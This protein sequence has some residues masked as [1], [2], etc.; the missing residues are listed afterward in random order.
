MSMRNTVVIIGASLAG[1][2]AAE[3]LRDEGFAGKIV[4]IGEEQDAPYDRPPLSKQLLT[5][6]WRESDIQLLN[7]EEWEELDIDLRLN[8]RA[9]GVDV[10]N[11]RV[12]LET[13][14]DVTYD[15]LIIATGSR[16]RTILTKPHEHAHVL[17]SLADARRL[18]GA[19][20]AG[21]RSLGIVGGGFIGS[22]VAYGARSLGH[23]VMVL[24]RGPGPMAQV[25]GPA[26]AAELAALQHTHGVNLRTDVVVAGVRDVEGEGLQI[27]LDDGSALAF[28]EVLVSVGAIPNVEWLADSGLEIDGGIVC[29]ARLFAGDDIV[30]AGDVVRVR[31]AGVINRRIEHWTDTVRQAQT[32]AANLLAGPHRALP[33]QGMPYVWSDQFGTRI[34]VIGDPTAGGCVEDVTTSDGGA[35][36]GRIFRYARDGNTVALVSVGAPKVMLQVRR[37]VLDRSALAPLRLA[38]VADV[39]PAK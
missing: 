11:H 3:A 20:S 15:G 37:A 32:A 18:A 30:A 29:D 6:K 13:G 17:R 27:L 24:E 16:P 21:H 14:T 19:L 23:D 10:K 2:R 1:T 4:L 7:G 8:T 33:L 35:A 36:P 39:V 38:D 9:V 25:F 34:E 26:V 12:R 31:D 22:E 28:D 5:G